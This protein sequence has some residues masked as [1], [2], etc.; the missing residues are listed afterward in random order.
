LRLDISIDSILKMSVE[1]QIIVSLKE[2]N[3]KVVNKSSMIFTV[4]HSSLH[5]KPLAVFLCFGLFIFILNSP[6]CTEVILN[7]YGWFGGSAEA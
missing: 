4:V 6:I 1:K 2:K 5:E 3:F 7:N